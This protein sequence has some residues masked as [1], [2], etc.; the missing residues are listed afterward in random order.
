MGV[1]GCCSLGDCVSAS[2]TCFDVFVRFSHFPDMKESLHYFSVYV[3]CFCFPD[4]VVP[5]AAVDYVCPWEEV[6]SG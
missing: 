2:P 1:G 5:H 3:F 6:S 4:E